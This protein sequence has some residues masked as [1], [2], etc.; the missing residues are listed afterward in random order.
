MVAGNGH[1]KLTCSLVKSIGRFRFP[2]SRHSGTLS[3][4]RTLNRV[5]S[6]SRGRYWIQIGWLF[7]NIASVP[8]SEPNDSKLFHPEHAEHAFGLHR[9]RDHNR[10]QRNGQRQYKALSSCVFVIL[11][12]DWAVARPIVRRPPLLVLARF[13]SWRSATKSSR[14]P[15]R[16]PTI[17]KFESGMGL[18]VQNPRS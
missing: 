10:G 5:L 16:L 6:R 12:A 17:S 4:S 2:E 18:E 14:S 8:A 13:C 15:Y 9:W 7:R 11:P 1:S 3:L